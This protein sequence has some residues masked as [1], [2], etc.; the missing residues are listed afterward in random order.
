MMKLMKLF[1]K[2]PTLTFIDRRANSSFNKF[3][4]WVY[5]EICKEHFEKVMSYC[6]P[7]MEKRQRA[8]IVTHFGNLFL[9]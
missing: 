1:V 7:E 4:V 3:Q 5:P 2:P 6:P 8:M 9:K